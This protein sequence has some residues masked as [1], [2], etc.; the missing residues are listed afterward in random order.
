MSYRLLTP[1]LDNT[2]LFILLVILQLG[3]AFSIEISS[4][5]FQSLLSWGFTRWN[6]LKDK[7]SIPPD[8]VFSHKKELKALDSL[9]LRLQNYFSLSAFLLLRCILAWVHRLWKF[10]FSLLNYQFTVSS[11]ISAFQSKLSRPLLLL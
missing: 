8:S 10:Y 5:W 6:F 2:C 1:G 9:V 7:I 11:L 4:S 3:N